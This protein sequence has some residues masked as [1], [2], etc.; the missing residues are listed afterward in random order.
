MRNNDLKYLSKRKILINESQREYASEGASNLSPAKLLE[1][2]NRKMK[3]NDRL[4][5]LF[6]KPRMLDIDNQEILLKITEHTR[7]ILLELKALGEKENDKEVELEVKIE[8]YMFADKFKG[9]LEELINK[10]RYNSN[11]KLFY[12]V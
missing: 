10:L 8:K 9:N 3:N 6:S 12:I 11:S 1:L 7:S 4:F 5:R 2:E